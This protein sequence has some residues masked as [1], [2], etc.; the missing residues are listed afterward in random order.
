MR[1]NKDVRYVVSILSKL[2]PLVPVSLYRRASSAVE[3]K[4]EKMDVADDDDDD[5]DDDERDLQK[6]NLDT[7]LPSLESREIPESWG[8][9][10]ST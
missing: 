4:D 8:K 6:R 9:R 5:D 7:E 3:D 2:I 1:T 10:E